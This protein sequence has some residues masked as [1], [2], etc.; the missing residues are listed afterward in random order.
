M[1]KCPR[2]K[3]NE[4]AELNKVYG[5]L[6]CSKCQAKDS[7]I[8]IVRPTETYSLAKSHRIQQARDVH[9]KDTIQPYL[10]NKPNPD[11]FKVHPDQIKKYG[12]RKELEKIS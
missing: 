10:S 6:P 9:A 11:Y 12:V 2:K 7:G 1:L 3:C 5:V 8:R 4:K